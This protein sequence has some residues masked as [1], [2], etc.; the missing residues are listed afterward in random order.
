MTLLRLAP[1]PAMIHRQRLI[2]ALAMALAA[3]AVAGP[4]VERRLLGDDR[5]T[6]TARTRAEN[7]RKSREIKQTVEAH[8]KDV[9]ARQR[10]VRERLNLPDPTSGGSGKA[11][12]KPN[13]PGLPDSEARPKQL[14]LPDPRSLTKTPTPRPKRNPVEYSPKRGQEFAFLVEMSTHEEGMQKQWIGTPYFAGVF[15]DERGSFSEMF[16]I[17][18]LAC[19]IRSSPDRP[20][21]PVDMEDIEL[22]EQFMF[23]SHGVLNA[24]TTSLF[25]QH[26]LPLQLSA[27]LPLEE[28]IFPALPMFL[29]NSRNESKSATTFFLR[30]GQRKFFGDTLTTP[31]EGEIR[32]VSRVEHETST[33]P[34][35]INERAFHC[36][37]KDIGLRF[38]QVGTIDACEAMIV[39]VDLDY[40]LELGEPVHLTASVRRLSGD[41]L[42]KA[43]TAALKK[44]PVAAWPEYFRR[45]PANNDEFSL[46][47]PRSADDIPAGQRIS[48]SIEIN[49]RDAHGFRDYLA[50]AI[51]AAAAGKVRVRLA[52]SNEEL[53]VHVTSVR[54]PK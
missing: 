10:A 12:T 32:R 34:Q 36:P 41:N 22:P 39:S 30:S 53:D 18:S 19:R 48:V 15:S 8:R 16:C 42:A 9:E 24:R 21:L 27:I 6:N 4:A 2:S 40:T 44:R 33:T 20:W 29:E 11:L 1:D 17:G 37:S 13:P 26:T 3:L 28:L 47:I 7:E 35:I 25:D 49:A 43:R 51:G 50:H 45:I 14:S 46:R 31:L 52:G 23:G 38:R 54:L 5:A